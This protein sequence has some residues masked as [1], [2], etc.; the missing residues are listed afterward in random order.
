MEKELV[1]ATWGLVVATALL[2]VVAIV[3][4][5]RDALD[6]RAEK[7][8][9]GA[10]IVPDMI[11]LRSRLEGASDEL[12]ESRSWTEQDIK[13]HIR[14]NDEELEMLDPIIEHGNRPS[15]LFVN[16]LYLV[17]HLLTQAKRRLARALELVDKTDIDDI[18][19]RDDALVGTRRAY[20]A[21]L[22]S[23]DAATQLLPRK[24]RTINGEGFWERFTRVSGEREAA[25]GKSF[26][27]IGKPSS[28][29]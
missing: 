5:I 2:A 16:E 20:T 17:R 21:A 22:T 6:R 26:I 9:T 19:T 27:S 24:V 28:K 15:L 7:L 10:G 3:P 1:H 23:L 4:L 8:R 18:R 13:D 29:K 12:A 11:I 14:W 25:A